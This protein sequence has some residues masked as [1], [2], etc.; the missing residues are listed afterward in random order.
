ML[1]AKKGQF[2]FKGVVG[3]LLTVLF[4]EMNLRLSSQDQEP[5]SPAEFAEVVQSGGFLEHTSAL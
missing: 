1:D 3:V 5:Y 4:K 2:C